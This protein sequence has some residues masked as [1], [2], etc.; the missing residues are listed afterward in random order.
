M[1]A[2]GLR[3]SILA[4]PTVP[5]P[6]PA[7]F[8][9]RWRSA[10]VT[11]TDEERSAFTLDLRRRAVRT[12]A[13]HSTAPMLTSPVV[14]GARVVL[15]VTFG[16]VPSVLMDGIVTSVELTPGDEPGAAT[17]TATGEDV[18]LLLDRVEKDAE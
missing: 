8:T 18:S 9:V 16:V 17:Y 5:L 7:A 2:P 10:R 11:E 13:R 14:T 3:L 4:G 12:A 1:A 15:V 6:L